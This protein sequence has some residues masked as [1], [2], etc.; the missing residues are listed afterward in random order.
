MFT[1]KSPS[2]NCSRISLRKTSSE[3]AG[4]LG[5]RGQAQWAPSRSLL[6]PHEGSPCTC[7]SAGCHTHMSMAQQTRRRKSKRLSSAKR[8]SQIRM[9]SGSKNSWDSSSVSQRKAK[10]WGL[11]FC[12]C[13]GDRG[14]GWGAWLPRSATQPITPATRVRARHTEWAT[15]LGRLESPGRPKGSHGLLPAG[16]SNI[17]TEARNPT[18]YISSPD[19]QT[20]A[21]I[22]SKYGVDYNLGFR[23]RQ[24][25]YQSLT[26]KPGLVLSMCNR[27]FHLLTPH[28][29]LT[30]PSFPEMS[31]P[32]RPSE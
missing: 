13:W 18:F 23:A 2:S 30:G 6:T 21:L 25:H 31:P 9:T 3:G 28:H 1:V 24:T 22:L 20:M 29:S 5:R 11:M 15:A 10:N 12:S 26:D 17:S 7:P 14:V 8:E 19:L 16:A 4:T 27:P 32:V